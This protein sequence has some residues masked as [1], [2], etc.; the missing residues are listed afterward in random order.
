[1]PFWEKSRKNIL[2]EQFKFN[3]RSQQAGEN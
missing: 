3:K 2:F 1:V